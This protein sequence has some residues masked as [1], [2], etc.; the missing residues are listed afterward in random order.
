MSRVVEAEATEH[1]LLAMPRRDAAVTGL[2]VIVTAVL[3]VAMAN[4]TTRAP[5]QRLDD[6]FLR[7]MVAIRTP[8]LTKVADTFNVLGLVVVTLPVRLLIAGYLALRR[9]WWHFSAFVSA[10][11]LSEVSIGLLKTLYHRAR[12]LGSLV[13]TSGGSFPSGHAV[14]ASVTAVAAV[15]AL[16][17]E[18]PRRYAWGAAAVAFSLVMALSRAY[19]AA[20]WLS[21]AITGVL[22]GTSIALGTALVVHQVRVRREAA[23]PEVRVAEPAT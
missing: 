19:L 7:Q 14:A 8:W 20:H 10:I 15:I 21:D 6:A 5:I 3:F 2:L 17:P 22:L 18:G 13:H 11:V 16:F 12:P 4:H 9:R 23:R 1:P